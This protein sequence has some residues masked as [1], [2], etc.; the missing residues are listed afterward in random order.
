MGFA[1]N[2]YNSCIA[3]CKINGKQC[4]IAWYV[5]DN[6]I[7]HV[8]LDV[9]TSIIEKIEERFDKMTVTRGKEHIFLGMHIQYTPG[10]AHTIHRQ[11][12]SCHYYEGIS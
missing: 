4:T 1:L 9:V 11:G 2:P 5:D 12:H 8:D 7:S 10:Y 6:M 3:N